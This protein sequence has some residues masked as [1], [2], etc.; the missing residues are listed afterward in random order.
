M[1]LESDG[2][3]SLHGTS[4]GTTITIEN[5]AKHQDGS[6]TDGTYDGTTDVQPMVQPMYTLEETI[7]NKEIKELNYKKGGSKTIQDM[8]REEKDEWLRRA[9]DRLGRKA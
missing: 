2:M 1:A 8:T 7:R 3:V 5:Y 6:T 4:H 9:Y